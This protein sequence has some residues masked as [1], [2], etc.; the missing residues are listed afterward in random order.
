[1]EQ[2]YQF[3]TDGYN[4]VEVVNDDDNM[5]VYYF[6]IGKPK[7]MSQ[8]AV[9]LNLSMDTI[10]SFADQLQF[11]NK[12]HITRQF[13]DR[14]VRKTLP[15]S[16][17]I[18]LARNVD[19]NGEGINPMKFYTGESTKIYDNGEIPEED[20]KWYLIY[21]ASQELSTTNL[22]NPVECY[23]TSDKAF[24]VGLL[25][26][27]QYTDYAPGTMIAITNI[28][29]RGK[30]I[31]YTSTT[32]V[33][34]S[35]SDTSTCRGFNLYFTPS[36]IRVTAIGTN[37]SVIDN[38][39]IFQNTQFTA[40]V[41]TEGDYSGTNIDFSKW[42]SDV[43]ISTTNYLNFRQQ[44]TLAPISSL[45]RTNSQIMKVIELP[46]APFDAEFY[47]DRLTIPDGWNFKDGMLKL[48]DLSS[49]F[50][51]DLG[52][53]AISELTLP[54]NLS[55]EV[56]VGVPHNIKYESK[57]YN[58]EF[59][60]YAVRYDS[61]EKEF[62]LERF[63]I[64]D[65]NEA[66]YSIEFKPTNTINGNILVDFKSTNN[67]YNEVDLRSKYLNIRR[68]LELPLLHSQYVD[69][70]RNGLRYDQKNVV[71]NAIFSG[72][73]AAGQ[74]GGSIISKV[75]SSKEKATKAAANAAAKG[76]GA[77]TAITLGVQAVISVANVVNGIITSEEAI[78][79]KLYE[80]KNSPA[81][82]DGADDLDLLNYM[83]G[84]KME[85]YNNRCSDKARLAIYNMFR[86]TGYAD[87]VYQVP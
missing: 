75:S 9:Q 84:N 67:R 1:M 13:H 65:V 87:D 10:M 54:V 3:G 21:K 15:V 11:S 63:K 45:D 19:E 52:Y 29:N 38:R 39:F 49:E 37:L 73:G 16:G 42:I 33:S 70:V 30:T 48:D 55:T 40:R 81:S 62:M 50:S 27:I 4:Y 46:Y 26:G 64:T 82:V 56:K 79:Q 77:A 12:T 60:T 78:N 80:L 5:T 35:L 6:I 61:F 85:I 14:F 47:Y 20:C 22:A 41:F 57:L 32:G 69:Y 36:G 71:K 34:Q 18:T 68:N 66:S 74:L 17:S 58:S 31:T 76:I 83:N 23:C 53:F 7:W 2:K 24:Q 51:N 86:L 25:N 28:D 72:I 59:Y 44:N 8:N 43:M